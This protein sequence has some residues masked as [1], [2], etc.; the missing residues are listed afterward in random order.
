M[1]ARRSRYAQFG[2]VQHQ[3]PGLLSLDAATAGATV[4]SGAFCAAAS[5]HA[6]CWGVV[7]GAPARPFVPA[8]PLNPARS[9][10]G[11]ILAPG[12]GEESF[13]RRFFQVTGSGFPFLLHG[14]ICNFQFGILVVPLRGN[15]F[16]SQ[17]EGLTLPRTERRHTDI[18]RVWVRAARLQ[19]V[20]R[21]CL[22]LGKLADGISESDFNYY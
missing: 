11:Q 7:R 19:N 12:Q 20:Q 1:R 18:D 13:A 8:L 17:P 4:G 21:N 6:Q 16:E 3:V 15:A 10:R 2:G 9:R 5:L 22:A 14:Y